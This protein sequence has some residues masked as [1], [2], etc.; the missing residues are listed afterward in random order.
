VTMVLVVDD[1]M[2]TRR[3]VVHTLKIFN[4]ETM[5]AGSG[6][7]ALQLAAVNTVHLAIVDINL[8]DVDG[9]TLIQRLKELPHMRSIPYIVFT[10]RNHADDQLRAAECGAV[11]F[12]YKPFST[13]ELRTLVSQHLVAE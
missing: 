1:E 10:A 4:V 7:E 12:L 9:F 11:G 6:E 2:V 3:I 13:Q 8:P 5:A